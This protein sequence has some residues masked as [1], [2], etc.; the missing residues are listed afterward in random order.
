MTDLSSLIEREGALTPE[1]ALRWLIQCI[2]ADSGSS[3]D[4]LSA[5]EK[6]GAALP[7]EPDEPLKSVVFM[8]TDFGVYGRVEI[9]LPV[10]NGGDDQFEADFEETLEFVKR[11]I[12]RRKSARAAALKA[13]NPSHEG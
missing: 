2:E 1:D 11:V 8:A 5:A 4:V 13:R 6:A 9:T 3:K 10:N 7:P 12:G